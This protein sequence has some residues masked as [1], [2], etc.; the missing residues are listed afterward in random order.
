MSLADV[1]AG[2]MPHIPGSPHSNASSVSADSP[3]L[4]RTPASPSSALQPMLPSDLSSA[5]AQLGANGSQAP[6]SSGMPN[7][8][9][10]SQSQAAA[11]AAAK[12]KSSRRANTAE[13]RAT[14]NAVERQRR[15]TLNGRFLDLAGLLPNL[16]QIRRPSKSAIVNSSIAHVHA[17][18]RHRGMAARELR[19]LRMEADAYRREINQWRERAG[20]PGMEE[21]VRSDAFGLVLAGELELEQELANLGENFEGEFLSQIDEDGYEEE[22]DYMQP[23]HPQQQ[24]QQQQQ[25]MAM[26]AAPMQ[27]SV[28]VV[29]PAHENPNPF[30]GLHRQMQQQQAAPRIMNTGPPASHMVNA[31]FDSTGVPYFDSRL[32]PHGHPSHFTSAPTAHYVNGAAVAVDDAAWMYGVSG[33]ANKGAY[34]PPMTVNGHASHGYGLGHNLLRSQQHQQQQVMSGAGHMYGSPIDGDDG[35]VGSAPSTSHGMPNSMSSMSM[36]VPVPMSRARSSST[37]AQMHAQAQQGYPGSYEYEQ[38]FLAQQGVPIPGH[39]GQ[40]QSRSR[41]LS[42]ST[43]ATGSS[44]HGHG[45][46]VGSW[47]G[48]SPMG[49]AVGG[50][51]PHSAMQMKPSPIGMQGSNVNM[52]AGAAMAMMF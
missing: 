23:P 17:S 46:N 25:Q 40:A 20:L 22:D 4:P 15:E 32:N 30:G 50:L 9:A 16:T 27:A 41:G 28:P 29:S 2:F 14:H 36:S 47:D 10:G 1:A 26:A 34:T 43:A 33:A 12:R 5:L 37:A 21:P 49:M 52:G 8:S 39:Q 42:V 31:G 38:E 44:L 19:H 35:S 18:R 45:H 7:S 11:A 48:M 3:T 51:S 24:Q 13:R 6:A